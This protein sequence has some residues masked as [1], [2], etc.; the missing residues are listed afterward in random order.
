M[1]SV[2]MCECTRFNRCSAPICPLDSDWKLR[3][4]RK[5]EPICFYLLE[6][7]KANARAQFKGSIGVPIYEAIQTSIDAMSHRYTPLYRALERAKRTGSRLV[8]FEPTANL[9]PAQGNRHDD[10]TALDR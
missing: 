3:V 10:R 2:K 1:N 5:G 9:S 6:Y 4:Y 8:Q 7:V